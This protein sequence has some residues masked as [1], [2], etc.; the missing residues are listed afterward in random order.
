M[1]I[2]HWSRMVEDLSM[3][4]ALAACGIS[5]NQTAR[6]V[7][8]TSRAKQ[9]NDDILFSP[10]IADKRLAYGASLLESPVFRGFAR[11]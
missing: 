5:R 1:E 3:L 2:S 6:R 7:A 8:E 10:R 11:G 4:M 9:L